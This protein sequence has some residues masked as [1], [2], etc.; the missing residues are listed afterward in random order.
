MIED[1]K[2]ALQD[3]CKKHRVII[4]ANDSNHLVTVESNPK[5]QELF[6]FSNANGEVIE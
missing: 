5:G 4:Y 2:A 3:F 1:V 6:S